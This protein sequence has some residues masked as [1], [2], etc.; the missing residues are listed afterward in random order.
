MNKP[1]SVLIIGMSPIVGGIETLLISLF[2]SIDKEKVHFDF[3]TFCDKCAFEEEIVSA[4]SKVYHAT[5]RGEDP[6]KNKKELIA[7]FKEHPHDYDYIWYHLSSASNCLPVVLAKKYTDAKIVCHSHG[8]SFDSRPIFRPIHL[9]LDKIHTPQLL[10]CT[11][12]CYACSAAAGK[13]LF[14][15]T[16]KPI[17]L[18]NN[19]VN[20]EKFRYKPEVREALRREFNLAPTTKVIGH[21]GRFCA[22]KNQTFLLDIFEAFHKQ[23]P[24]SVLLLAGT[25]ET[26][27]AMK[28]KAKQLGIQDAV[29][30]LGFRSDLNDLLQAFDLFLM[31]SFFEGLP[32]TAI[33]A[34]TSGLPCLLADTITEETAITDIV[35]FSAL[36]APLQEWVQKAQEML[37]LQQDRAQYALKVKEAGYDFEDTVLEVLNFFTNEANA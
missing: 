30:F 32:I 33:E 36:D 4:G 29:R 34:Q 22:T 14:K 31:P 21:A 3:L 24:D 19:G 15:D 6:I 23:N 20:L 18:L 5:R 9:F 1:V 8:T 35:Q 17:H 10:R 2:R 13:W 26:L 7:F 12:Y 25:G 16:D 28:E 11:D 27:D 37:S